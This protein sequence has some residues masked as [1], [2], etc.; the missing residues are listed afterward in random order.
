[1]HTTRANM[2]SGMNISGQTVTIP[3]SK[4]RAAG[5]SVLWLGFALGALWLAKKSMDPE[6]WYS[7]HY[8][9]NGT[10]SL[11]RWLP[12]PAK[13][14]LLGLIG[15]GLL[16]LFAVTVQRVLSNAPALIMDADGIEGYKN[17]ISHATIRMRWDEIGDITSHYGTLSI[18]SKR[19][20]MLAKRKVI[21]VQTDTVGK[22][23]NDI[24]A[25]MQAFM[26][27]SRLPGAASPQA[28]QYSQAPLPP[29]PSMGMASRS[30]AQQLQTVT[31][32]P[33]SMTNAAKP[34]FG[35]RRNT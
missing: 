12:V 2:D 26:L 20:S 21:I 25:T 9:I 7:V 6:F 14:G 1:M 16:L 10:T 29:G 27:A 24:V 13:V 8:N 17:N 5:L 11:M 15:M 34:A 35:T 3:V 32:P 31:R 30:A 18:Y 23:A 19:E 22:S 4:T 33:S 28:Q